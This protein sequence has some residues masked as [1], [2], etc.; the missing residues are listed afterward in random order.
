MPSSVIGQ[1]RR[2][3]RRQAREIALAYLFQKDFDLHPWTEDLTR[4]FAYFQTAAEVREFA[5]FL[6][7]GTLAERGGLD[8]AIE[9]IS[10]HWKIYRMDAI[11]RNI[12][13]MAAFE[14]KS[15]SETDIPVIIDEAVELAQR[16]GGENSAAFVNGI[17]DRLAAQWR[18]A[19]TAAPEALIG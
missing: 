5:T 10:E 6:V 15:E 7:E 9:A 8:S 13:R 1:S 12:L 16:F 19:P 11:D 4:F 18:P 3:R 2:G 17:L 14:I